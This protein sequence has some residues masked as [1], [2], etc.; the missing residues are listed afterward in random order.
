MLWSVT[1]SGIDSEVFDLVRREIVASFGLRVL[2][3]LSNLERAGMFSRAARTAAQASWL[4]FPGFGSGGRTVP[5]LDVDVSDTA[6]VSSFRTNVTSSS[7]RSAAPSVASSGASTTHSWQF[8]RAALRLVTSFD[9]DDDSVSSE[10]AAAP[11]LGYVPLSVRLIEAALTPDGWAR[12]PPVAPHTALL[13]LG[14]AAVEHRAATAPRLEST[15]SS[16]LP[17]DAIVVFVGG[18]TRAEA[19]AT[20]LA[21]RAAGKRALILATHVVSADEFISSFSETLP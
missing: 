16:T 15:A 5:E 8:A 19:S 18:V 9:P 10:L 2:P 12:L 17:F 14:H 4:D 3:L 11:Y 1:S 21:A 20:R 6:S 13:P 7:M